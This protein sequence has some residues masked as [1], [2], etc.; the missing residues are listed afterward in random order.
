MQACLTHEHPDA[1]RPQRGVHRH[2]DAGAAPHRP[3]A[4]GS[5]AKN[6]DATP[7][8]N[9]RPALPQG[10]LRLT[11]RL[12]ARQV[13][14]H[15]CHRL[16]HRGKITM[17]DAERV[18]QGTRPALDG[19]SAPWHGWPRHPARVLKA[20]SLHELSDWR[21]CHYAIVARWFEALARTHHATGL[22]ITTHLGGDQPAAQLRALTKHGVKR[23]AR[24][25]S[26]M[27]TAKASPPLTSF[28]RPRIKAPT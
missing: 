27:R 8:W 15:R 23:P 11:R 28:S 10:D 13:S 2:P 19:G 6:T 14:H 16:L 21:R 24:L 5:C 17:V 26:G 1:L 22:P 25:P 18:R 9:A 3:L 4:C 7:W 20:T 12:R